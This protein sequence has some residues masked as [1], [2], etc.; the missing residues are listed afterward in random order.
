MR[1]GD[2]MQGSSGRIKDSEVLSINI[3]KDCIVASQ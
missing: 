3:K 1:T 2:A